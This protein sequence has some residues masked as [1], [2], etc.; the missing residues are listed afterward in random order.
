MHALVYV[1]CLHIA[2]LNNVCS[3]FADVEED[4]SKVDDSAGVGPSECS[5]NDEL[6]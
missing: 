3:T 2:E 6:L 5:L 4:V 1:Q